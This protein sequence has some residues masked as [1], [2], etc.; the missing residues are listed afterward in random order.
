MSRSYRV[1]VAGNPNAG[2]STLFNRLTGQRARVGNYPGI[3]VELH[4]GRLPIGDTMVVDLVDIPGAYS[5]A[6][7][8][9]EEQ[10]AMQAVAGLVPLSRPDAVLLVVDATQL[11]RNLYLALQVLEL[12]VPVVVALTMIDRL[13]ESGQSVD[14]EALSR[15]LGVPVVEVHA[16]RGKGLQK[17]REVLALRLTTKDSD[18]AWNFPGS[19]SL[20]EDV[21][22]VADQ[23]PQDWGEGASRR[24]ALARWALLSIEESEDFATSPHALRTTVEARRVDAARQGRDL[25]QE[26]I[27][28]RYSWIDERSA[29]FLQEVARR[30]TSMTDRLDRV[31]L[32]PGWG[33]LLFLGLMALVF[34]SLFAWADP[35]IG[36]IETGVGV[37]AGLAESALPAGILRDFLVEGVIGGVGGVLV[38]FPQILLLFFFLGLM[39]DTGYMARIVYLMDRLMKWVGLQGRAFVPMLSGFACAVPAILATRTLERRRDRMLTMMVI[40]LMTCSARLPVYG[41]LIAALYPPGQGKPFTQGMMMVGMYLFSTVVALGVTAVLGKT[42][43]RG[44]RAPLLME[45]PPYRF[46]HLTSVLRMMWEKTWLFA[47]EAGTVILVCTIVMWVLLSFPGSDPESTARYAA[48][49]DR[50]ESTVSSEQERADQLSLLDQQE[51]GELLRNSYGGR[52]GR[53]LEP[54]FE[55]LGF[56]WKIGVGLIGAFAAREVFVSTMAVVYGLAEDSDEESSALR[57]RV[58]SQTRADGSAL[59]TPLVCFS[60]MV[61]FA[62]SCQCMSTLAVLKRETGTYRWPAFLFVYMTVLAWGASFAVFQGGRWIGL[63]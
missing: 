21:N 32:H 8:S 9:G 44:P 40:P 43:F 61:F 5:L 54:V 57:D 1:V 3:T 17:L 23:I 19:A 18:A 20:Q 28:T 39:E 24:Q 6:A 36:G 27:Q 14:A 50:I 55:P 62:L 45:M 37:V 53:F 60:L 48:E 2:K 52:L 12:G 33:F 46:P 16:P 34:Q 35:M 30:K 26:I 51:S 59:Y 10:I 38:F 25:E 29:S 4:E 47:R 11:R 56:D 15:E 41:L 22:A 49:R 63:S 58:R 31:L 7:R 13:H 42:V